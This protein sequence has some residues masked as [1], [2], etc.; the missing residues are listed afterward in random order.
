MLALK[1]MRIDTLGLASA[2]QVVD[3]TS[4]PVVVVAD[5]GTAPSA[6]R[7]LYVTQ[8]A[9]HATVERSRPIRFSRVK[10]RRKAARKKVSASR[11]S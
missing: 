4:S 6:N 8:V 9:E 1:T 10:R 2:S 5:A 11:K 3:R 7:T